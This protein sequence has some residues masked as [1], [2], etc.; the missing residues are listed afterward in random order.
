MRL[1]IRKTCSREQR[2]VLA[3]ILNVCWVKTE[4]H[5]FGVCQPHFH[6]I[7]QSF[8]LFRHAGALAE[9]KNIKIYSRLTVQSKC[10]R[11][12]GT[13]FGTDFQV[14]VIEDWI[15]QWDWGAAELEDKVLDENG[16]QRVWQLWQAAV[17]SHQ[18]E[19]AGE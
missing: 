5:D 2:D 18:M 8:F 15:W 1:E 13:G 3:E 16:E 6:K 14:G 10:A 17:W 19:Q 12:Q 7:N 9:A 11:Q 4:E